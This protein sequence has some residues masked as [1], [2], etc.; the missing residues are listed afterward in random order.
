VFASR[1]PLRADEDDIIRF[2]TQVGKVRDIRLITDRNSRKS[3]GFAYIE[4][5]DKASLPAAMQL[6]GT[7][8][9]GQAIQVQFSNAEKNR[10]QTT[11]SSAQTSFGPTRLYVG[12]LHFNITEDDLRLVFVPFGDIEFIDLHK[13]AETGRSKGFA[14]IQFKRAED[15]KRAL[16]Q[17]NGL[18]VA[19]RQIKVGYVTDPT[20]KTSTAPMEPTTTTAGELDDDEGGLTLNAQARALLM[21]KLQRGTSGSPAISMP[22][23][24]LMSTA[25]PL[26]V[27]TNVSAVAQG[28]PAPCLLLRNLFDPSK[29]TEPNWDSDIRED[30][31]EECKAFG[32]VKHIHVD[33]LSDGFVYVK[34]DSISA[35]QNALNSLNR[36][37]FAGRMI[38]AEFIPEQ[39]YAQMFPDSAK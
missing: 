31:L 4:F 21:A 5:F 11:A 17:V 34:F 14:F 10:V 7:P 12:S 36:R 18:E 20:S 8:F 37:W 16:Q 15:A 39:R 26:N 23:P 29:E 3:K 1:L 35:A 24:V 6:T 33:R 32:N 30:V 25:P 9:M 19:G 28:P 13:D 38:T 27:G 22:A 2:F